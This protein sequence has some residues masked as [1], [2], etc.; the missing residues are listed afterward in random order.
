MHQA[1]L[2]MDWLMRLMM[3][4][5]STRMLLRWDRRSSALQCAKERLSEASDSNNGCLHE[6]DATFFLQGC[7]A[8]VQISALQCSM[9]GCC[10]VPADCSTAQTCMGQL[11]SK[12]CSVK[13]SAL[14]CSME[15]LMLR[16]LSQCIAINIDGSLYPAVHRDRANLHVLIN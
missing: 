3:T 8:A 10:E 2:F 1:Y 4:L 15:S 13:P 5:L 11:S 16:R 9:Q 6:H 14:Q 7:N 12:D